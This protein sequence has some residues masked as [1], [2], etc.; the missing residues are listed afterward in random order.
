MCSLYMDPDP[1][2]SKL[3]IEIPYKSK[4][5]NGATER[6]VSEKDWP[7]LDPGKIGRIWIRPLRGNRIRI[8]LDKNKSLFIF[9]VLN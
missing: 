9:Y 7:D 6:F 2:F 4:S 1:M 3:H 8:L 5:N